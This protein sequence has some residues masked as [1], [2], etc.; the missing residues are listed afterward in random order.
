MITS[1]DFIEAIQHHPT[2]TIIYTD[3]SNN[4]TKPL[5]PSGSAAIITTPSSTLAIT[6]TCPIKGSYPAEIYSILMLTTFPLHSLPQPIIIPIDNLSTCSTLN[7]IMSH[8][9]FPL[10]SSIDPFSFWY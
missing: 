10:S 4:P 9:H 2:A 3:G 5:L 6:S 8:S 7:Y 1:H